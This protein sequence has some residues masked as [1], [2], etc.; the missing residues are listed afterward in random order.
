MTIAN[1]D[2]GYLDKVL[3]WSE[4]KQISTVK[5]PRLVRSALANNEFWSLWRQCKDSMVELGIS[6]KKMPNGEWIVSWFK[7][8][9]RV[10]APTNGELFPAL[11]ATAPAPAAPVT[12]TRVAS[13]VSSERVWSEEQKA[14]FEW[15]RSGTGSL[16]VRARAGTGKTTTIKTAF[17]HAPEDRMLYAVFNK[18]NQL[19]ASGAIFDPRV[20]I[21]TLHSVGFM[22]IQQVWQNAK[23]TDEV[24]NFRVEKVVGEQSPRE[25]KT[26]VKKLVGFAKNMFVNPSLTELTELA[27]ER[28][29]ECPAFETKENG[30]WDRNM[31]AMAA[32]KVLELSKTRD[33]QGRISFNDMVWLPVAMNWVRA[34]YDLVV[35]DE[36]QDMNLPQ[37]LMA[38]AACKPDG[39]I[40]VVGDDRQAIYRFRGAASGGMDMMKSLLNATELGLT[41]TYRCPKKVVAL[42]AA[43]VADYKAADSAPE[44]LVEYTMTDKIIQHVKV[45]DAILSRANAP[46]MPMCLSLLRRGTP[47]RIEGRDIGKALQDIVDKI[48]ARTVPQF[49][50]RIEIWREKQINR[51]SGSPNLEEKS[52][53]INDQADT[54]IAIAEGASSV[55]EI[56]ARLSALFADTTADSKPAVILSTVHRAKGLEWTKVFLMA[57][58]FN[59]KRPSSAPPIS[60]DLAAAQAKEEANIYYVALTRAKAHLVLASAC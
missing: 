2:P 19:E 52:S 35:V 33:E 14:I 60:E 45:G 27:E 1:I 13:P 37:L 24:E 41:T 44:G 50:T 53:Q 47:A 36:A 38:K 42:A 10:A 26:Q 17:S 11:P 16:I 31:L 51:F 20:E 55:N 56:S 59:R 12:E 15:F 49:I 28:D 30:G 40:C 9:S 57:S 6:P 54:L 58:T 43:I 23:P 22:F 29:V 18:K 34:W 46:L 4:A 5:G 8:V 3:P 7:P 48:N 39:R 25:V 21:R 32:L